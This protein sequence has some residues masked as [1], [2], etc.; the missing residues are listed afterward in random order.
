MEIAIGI[1][2]IALGLG[3]Y[4][5]FFKKSSCSC[6]DKPTIIVSDEDHVD[7]I[8]VDPK[9]NNKVLYTLLKKN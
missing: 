5:S 4:A 3:V 9:R 2:V 7:S 1:S 6:E 8:L